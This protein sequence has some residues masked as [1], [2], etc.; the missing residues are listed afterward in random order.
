MVQYIPQS[1][2]VD[3]ISFSLGRRTGYAVSWLKQIWY[4]RYMENDWLFIAKLTVA[5]TFLVQSYVW[6]NR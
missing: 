3:V 4:S 2:L 6:K 5:S 1:D